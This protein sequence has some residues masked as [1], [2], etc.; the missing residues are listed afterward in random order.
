[1][2]HAMPQE[3][4]EKTYAAPA[5]LARPDAIGDGVR[6]LAGSLQRHADVIKEELD[7]LVRDLLMRQASTISVRE[8]LIVIGLRAEQMRAICRASETEL[9]RRASREPERG[10]R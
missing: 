5:S 1:M 10:I 2:P 8:H 7:A 6:L 9:A 4:G 3:S